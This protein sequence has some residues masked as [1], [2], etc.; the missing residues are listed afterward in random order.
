MLLSV[1]ML[2]CETATLFMTKA[3]FKQL[4]II[5]SFRLKLHLLTCAFCRKFKIQSEFINHKI[6]CISI[7]DNE[8]IAHHLSE[9][10][11]NKISQ[12]IDNNIN[13]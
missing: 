12:L 10:Q 11:K 8:Q 3:E 4:N 7:V 5:D 6:N 1:V 13:K 9:I 2:N